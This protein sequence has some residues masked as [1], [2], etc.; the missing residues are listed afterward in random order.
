MR[1]LLRNGA[2]AE[3]MH[4]ESRVRVTPELNLRYLNRGVHKS[5]LVCVCCNTASRQAEVM[6]Q[7]IG[8]QPAKTL[9][10]LVCDVEERRARPGKPAI[11]RP[12]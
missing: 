9:A 4:Y 3:R 10:K 1:I 6:T 8:A 12:A 7:E 2:G 11:A 5:L